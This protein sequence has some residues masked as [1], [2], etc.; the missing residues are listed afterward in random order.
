MNRAVT[1]WVSFNVVAVAGFV[2]QAAALEI[3]LQVGGCDYLGA[4]ALAVEI[5]VLHNFAWH[6]RWT[7]R[8]RETGPAAGW[9][10]LLLRYHVTQGLFSL[11]GTVFFMRLLV[12]GA[13]SA[14]G[15]GQPVQYGTVR[16]AFGSEVFRFGSLCLQTTFGA[17]RR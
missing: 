17:P 6:T 11:V 3:L 15:S 10:P 4:S 8:G 7:W 1:T 16:F 9:I 5:A 2:V 12:G 14:A 13:G